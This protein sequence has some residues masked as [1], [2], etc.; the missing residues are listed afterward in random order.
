MSY[1]IEQLISRS[2]A[3]YLK[4]GFT[5]RLPPDDLDIRT[6]TDPLV[7]FLDTELFTEAGS[8]WSQEPDAP[9]YYILQGRLS[10]RQKELLF[11]TKSGIIAPLPHHI[12][13]YEP[14]ILEGYTDLHNIL[15]MISK[16]A[17]DTDL[18]VITPQA[19]ALAAPFP[20][21]YDRRFFLSEYIDL[22]ESRRKA[23]YRF[24][25]NPGTAQY[26]FLCMAYL[27]S[28]MI[29]NGNTLSP[30]D[31]PRAVEAVELLLRNFVGIRFDRC[32]LLT[33][34]NIIEHSG[35]FHQSPSWH[36]ALALWA[37]CHRASAWDLPPAEALMV[38]RL[39]N[40]PQLHSYLELVCTPDALRSM[41]RSI[42]DPR[43]H[44]VDPAQAD[45]ILL[46][47]LYTGVA[48]EKS[49]IANINRYL[50]YRRPVA[51][52]DLR[53]LNPIRYSDNPNWDILV[54]DLFEKVA[55]A[56][57]TGSTAYTRALALVWTCDTG[58]LKDAASDAQEMILSGET[59]AAEL[60]G[61]HM[62]SLML[63]HELTSTSKNRTPIQI[64]LAQPIL[65]KLAEW[66]IKCDDIHYSAAAILARDLVYWGADPRP[67]ADPRIRETAIIRKA[68]G[69][70]NRLYP[71]IV[72]S[73]IDKIV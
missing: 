18:L 5:N 49:T 63:Q 51:L 72:L 9:D 59:I 23:L 27:S 28:L 24:L 73:L 29:R 1:Y 21:T 25:R 14:G 67:L 70:G 56:L 57:A 64:E 16:D 45:H 55:I 13:R 71:S 50:F 46:Q 34:M 44:N 30:M 52:E 42:A 60:V 43:L 15:L 61:V 7:P 48:L 26:C 35:F 66:L 12:C 20:H 22:P 53:K 65:Q 41:A 4:F 19:Y 6:V 40:A 2:M 54:D 10:G 69:I 3:Y 36:M 8:E 11:S 62:L 68:A 39:G 37:I 38:S 47:L 58:S 33:L 32:D 31:D 17:I